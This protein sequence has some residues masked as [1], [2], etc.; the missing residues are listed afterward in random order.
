MAD[1]HQVAPLA[2]IH[3]LPGMDPGSLRRSLAGWAGQRRPS[4]LVPALASELGTEAFSTILAELQRADYLA[5]AVLALGRA[6]PRDSSR[7]MA[8]WGRLPC[9]TAVVWPEGPELSSA[10]AG[11]RGTVDPGPPGK[12]RDVW[13]ALGYI[14]SGGLCHAVALH[15][16]DIVTYTGDMPE[17]LLA[18]L[19][20]PDLDFDFC[21]GYYPRVSSGTLAGRVT[22][23]LVSPLTEVVSRRAESLFPPFVSAFRYPLAGEFALTTDLAWRLPIP[24]DWGLEIGILSAVWSL[25]S[26]D[27][28]CQAQICSNYEHK[29]QALSPDDATRGLNLM[30][31]E[32]ASA[33]LRASAMDSAAA[34]GLVDEYRDAAYQWV[35]KYR[36][37]ALANG[38]AY[39]EEGEKS[40]VGTFAGALQAAVDRLDAPHTDPPLPPWQKV[41]ENSPGLMEAIREAV[42][43]E[44]GKP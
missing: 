37:D 8:L 15:D 4:L 16:A 40:A 19:L 3:C 43:K 30:A 24:R 33:F 14:L 9:R 39:D 38:L 26:P 29:H 31:V 12:G 2:T 6:E 1:F 41:R 21:K 44:G 11:C 17:K 13:I 20:H 7:A 18:P 36:A 28:V 34:R 32:V 25:V 35:P 23:L 42:E 5:E 22:R 10:L 27:R